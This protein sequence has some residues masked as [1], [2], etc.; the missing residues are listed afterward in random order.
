L[1]I[2]RTV[3]CVGAFAQGKTNASAVQAGALHPSAQR[4]ILDRP[5]LLHQ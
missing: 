3:N 1:L 4:V 2:S 5:G